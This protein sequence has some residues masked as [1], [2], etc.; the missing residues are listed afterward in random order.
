MKKII[1]FGL[2]LF[3]ANCYGQSYAQNKPDKIKGYKIQII[4][5]DDTAPMRGYL[6]E[7]TDSSIVIIP[8]NSKYQFTGEESRIEVPIIEIKKIKK[9]I[10]KAVL[11]GAI[12]GFIGGA[13]VGVVGAQLGGGTN[14]AVIGAGILFGV[15]GGSLTAGIT[16]PI[17][18]KTYRINGNL[19]KY[20][21]K[22]MRKLR[23]KSIAIEDTSLD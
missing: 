15:I 19:D 11:I 21:K 16:A 9:S 13:F 17:A 22:S 1:F 6:Y 10:K 18:S 4:F 5:L 14:G 2:I 3:S 7:A 23:W 20:R 8:T 12:P